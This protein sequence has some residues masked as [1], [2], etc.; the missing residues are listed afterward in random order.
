[1]ID[2]YIAE[3]PKRGTKEPL[4]CDLRQREIDGISNER[5]K[6]EK[7]YVWKLLECAAERS[8]GIKASAIEFKKEESGRYVTDKFNFSLSHS[9]GVLA[10]AI[11]DAY[12]G[13]DVERITDS[14]RSGLARRY[15]TPCEYANYEKLS[16]EEKPRYF[17][18]TW[19]AKEAVFKHSHKERFVP[20]DI[21]TLLSPCKTFEKSIN[22][23]GYFL[24]VAADSLNELRIFEDVTL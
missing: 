18:K 19:T 20:F 11:S 9:G 4:D 24:S 16:D 8:F 15:M 7:Y 14:H 22:Q 23:I 13:V 3:L 5:F 21:D 1:M 12:V 10:V 17:L 2:I 6:R